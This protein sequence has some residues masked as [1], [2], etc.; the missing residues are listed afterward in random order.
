MRTF[1]QEFDRDFSIS[2]FRQIDGETVIMGKWGRIT[3]NDDDSYDCWFVSPDLSPLTEHK[4]TAIQKK[5]RETRVLRRMTGEADIQG[6][7]RDFV[8]EMAVLA[9]VKKKRKG[10]AGRPFV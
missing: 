7:G 6:T 10:I 8:L 5:L 9:G 4:I 1:R 2:A 3:Q